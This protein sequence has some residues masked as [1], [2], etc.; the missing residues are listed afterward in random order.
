[1][2]VGFRGCSCPWLCRHPRSGT[3]PEP[4]ASLLKDHAMLPKPISRRERER[5]WQQPRQPQQAA[6]E[7]RSIGTRQ[8]YLDSIEQL[9]RLLIPHLDLVFFL[10]LDPSTARADAAEPPRGDA[11]GGAGGNVTPTAETLSGDGPALISSLSKGSEQKK[12]LRDCGVRGPPLQPSYPV[13]W[14]QPERAAPTTATPIGA[15]RS[16]PP[17]PFF[18][19]FPFLL[20]LGQYF[21][22]LLS[23]LLCSAPRQ[24][25]S[26]MSPTPRYPTWEMAPG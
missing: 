12:H 10:T 26:S 1:M 21:C 6:F 9:W 3:A 4:G 15:A 5:G 2:L 14:H 24:H 25:H 23:E 13:P 7:S 20:E 16:P 8:I 11:P 18:I 19:F 17:P 22:L